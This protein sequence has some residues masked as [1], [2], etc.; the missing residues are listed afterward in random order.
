MCGT[1]LEPPDKSEIG[2]LCKHLSRQ[3]SFNLNQACLT[4]LHGDPHV[5]MPISFMRDKNEGFCILGYNAM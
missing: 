2:E 5:F 1:T 3:L 4:I